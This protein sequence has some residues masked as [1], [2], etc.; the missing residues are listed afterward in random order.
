AQSGAGDDPSDR[1]LLEE[2]LNNPPPGARPPPSLDRP[3]DEG[4]DD[5]PQDDSGEFNGAVVGEVA[6]LPPKRQDPVHSLGND[7]VDPP[8]PP[9]PAIRENPIAVQNRGQ[10]SWSLIANSKAAGAGGNAANALPEGSDAGDLVN[11]KAATLKQSID[12]T[13]SKGS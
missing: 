5:T 2:P 9:D 11:V 7:P 12:H 6:A 13:G 8:V 3:P 10:K 1:P 4:D